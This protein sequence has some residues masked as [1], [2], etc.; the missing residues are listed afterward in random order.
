MALHGGEEPQPEAAGGN[1][2]VK[3]AAAAAGWWR[4]SCWAGRSRA[5]GDTQNG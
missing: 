4:L 5:G 3:V 2:W 1:G